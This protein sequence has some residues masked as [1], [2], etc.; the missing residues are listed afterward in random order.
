MGDKEE[1]A[2]ETKGN[3]AIKI[4]RPSENWL[5]LR[6]KSGAFLHQASIS[7]PKAFPQRQ[8]D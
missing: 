7:S 8:W 4:E 6:L 3:K 2:D 5:D 1:E